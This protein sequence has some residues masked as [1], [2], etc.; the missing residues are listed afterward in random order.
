M[1]ISGVKLQAWDMAADYQLD[2]ATAGTFGFYML[3]TRQT[4]YQTQLLPDQPFIEKVGITA[5]YPSKLKLNAGVDWKRGGWSAGW[6]ARYVS[7]YLSSTSS[8][9]TSQARA[10]T[11]TSIPRCITMCLRPVV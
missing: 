6:A 8:S 4:H 5:D 2:T 1:N 10:A 9:H 7:S 11:A 3:G